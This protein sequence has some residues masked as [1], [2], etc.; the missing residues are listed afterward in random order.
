MNVRAL[1]H[2]VFAR[3]TIEARSWCLFTDDFAIGHGASA[4]PN[5]FINDAS[6]YRVP[7]FGD[8]LIYRFK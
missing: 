5:F 1:R 7:E 3:V 2:C 8:K 6:Y 4:I